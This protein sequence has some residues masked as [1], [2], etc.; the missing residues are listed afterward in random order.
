MFSATKSFCGKNKRI[1]KFL[2]C[3]NTKLI[4]DGDRGVAFKAQLTPA[5]SSISRMMILFNEFGEVSK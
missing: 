1:F 5:A 3:F 4:H 2:V